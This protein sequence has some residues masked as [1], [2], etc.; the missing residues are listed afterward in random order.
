MNLISRPN[1]ITPLWLCLNVSLF[2]VTNQARMFLTMLWAYE[3]DMCSPL[4]YSLCGHMAL[5]MVG[6]FLAYR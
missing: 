4:F 5:N 2:I 6:V 1:N 3:G